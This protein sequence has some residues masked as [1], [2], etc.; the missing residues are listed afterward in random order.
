MKR[1]LIRRLTGDERGVSAIEFALI[2]PVMIAFYMGMTEFCQ[3]F[4]AQKRMGHV[5]SMVADLVSQN[6]TVTP[7]TVDDIFDI[8]GLIMAP[9]P[10]ATLRQRV[11]SVTLSSGV[12]RVDW[13]R[14][15]G[16]GETARATGSAIDIPA[17]LI[18]EGQSLIVSEVT[19]DYDS[20]ADYLMP[21][22]TRFEQSQ[23]LRPRK[24]EMTRCPTCPVT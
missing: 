11:S 17:D 14:S 21:G 4:M 3:G 12:A 18:T 16:E 1:S 19:Y 10:T 22:L 2:A 20:A 13:S 24:S 23:Y 7:A 15:R 8:G 9:F 5:S 6:D